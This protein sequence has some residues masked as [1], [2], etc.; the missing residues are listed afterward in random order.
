MSDTSK[1]GLP[2][3]DAGLFW[4]AWVVVMI[5]LLG[6][7]SMKQQVRLDALEQAC[8]IEVVEVEP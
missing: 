3:S 6:L 4:S 5:I 2:T 1:R 7:I 8:G